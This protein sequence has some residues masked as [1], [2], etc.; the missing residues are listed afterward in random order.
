VRIR[1]QA[2]KAT[3]SLTHVAA[4][5][6]DRQHPW[7]ASA[8]QARSV[9]H[10]EAIAACVTHMREHL[11]D[12]MRLDDLSQR[13]AMSKFHFVRTFERVTGAPPHCFLTCLRIDKAKQLLAGTKQ[14]ITEICWTVGY[15]SLGTF[16]STFTALVGMTPTAYRQ[17]A[18]CPPPPE[19]WVAWCLLHSLRHRPCASPSQLRGNIES[20]MP[21]QDSIIF[22]GAFDRGAPQGR[23]MCGTVAVGANRYFM[24][25]PPAP[26]FRLLAV[27]LS[28]QAAATC[29]ATGL[30][31]CAV[32]TS[33]VFNSEYVG[34][35]AG[36][37]RLRPP[38][39]VDPP[40]I[41]EPF[42]LLHGL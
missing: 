21:L 12:P 23:P 26:R 19:Q 29:G 40:V 2:L 28:L 22:V 15:A 16:S 34:E 1:T 31:V 7:P 36:T 25:R 35:S 39:D 3:S 27:Q 5:G 8:N 14:P 41:V 20:C 9:R 24:D 37:L 13:V 30:A 38:N 4:P 6:M 10:R 42:A 18:I 32:G 33:E 11:A 17:W